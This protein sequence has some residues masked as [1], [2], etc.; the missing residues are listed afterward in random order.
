MQSWRLVSVSLTVFTFVALGVHG[1]TFCV[2]AGWVK[3]KLMSE[4]LLPLGNP[5]TL[6]AR[7]FECFFELADKRRIYF[8]EQDVQSL[9]KYR[10]RLDDDISSNKC[11]FLGEFS[12]LAAKNISAFG[13]FA[14]SLL[15]SP[16]QF[17]G[18]AAAPLAGDTKQPRAKDGKALRVIW[19]SYLK[20]EVLNNIFRQH[21]LAESAVEL[22]PAGLKPLEGPARER[23]KKRI[24][25][26]LQSING[27][28]ATLE[29]YVGETLLR[30]IPNAFDPHSQFFTEPEMVSFFDMLSPEELSFGL[31]LEEGALGELKVSRMVPGGPAWRSNQVNQGDVIVEMKT[32][33]GE[34]FDFFDMSAEEATALLRSQKYAQAEITFRKTDGEFAKVNLAKAVVSNSENVIF[35]LIL[36]GEKNIGYISLPAF[37]SA[38]EAGLSNGCSGSVMQ[39]IIK[40][41]R[42]KIDGL[43]LDLRYNGGGDVGEAIK[44]AGAFIDVGPVGIFE[45]KKSGTVSLKDVNRGTAY[46]GPLI[47]MVN[48]A[49]ASA[50][51]LVAAA[52]QDYNRA[53]IVGTRSYGKATAQSVAQVH[54]KDAKSGYL[55]IT[56]ERLYRING[57]TTQ[58]RGVVPDIAI[59]DLTSRFVKGESAL[60]YAIRSDSSNKKMY[61]QPIAASDYKELMQK[62]ADRIAGNSRFKRLKQWEALLTESLPANE[63]AFCA[64][65]NRF[66]A[67]AEDEG[68]P[69]SHYSVV[70]AAMNLGV[71]EVDKYQQEINKAFVDEISHSMYVEETYLIMLDLLQ[72]KK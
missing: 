12:N 5:D 14:D 47:I 2:R 38:T 48:G 62:S 7:T 56:G 61:Y 60:A 64:F 42:E 22:T 72:S 13:R 11:Q 51:E 54:E 44:L 37:F 69:S 19:A 49:S 59:P 26:S 41:K 71:L 23:V 70:N 1:Q 17:T 21:L 29:T 68:V 36:K 43:I 3:N 35:S 8:S 46:S 9:A 67:F 33:P 25:R 45:D 55:K 18:A 16:V 66:S 58:Q 20:S 27:T 4:H 10:T 34:R 40:L 31:E 32:S 50:S 28:P 65:V 57:K 52:M 63:A 53:I 24:Q 15:S 39:E 6:S 30:A